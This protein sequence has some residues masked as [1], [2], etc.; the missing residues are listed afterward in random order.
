MTIST[1]AAAEIIRAGIGHRT[2]EAMAG[3]I[4]A[5]G[6]AEGDHAASKLFYDLFSDGRWIGMAEG[7]D[8]DD[9]MRM[10]ARHLPQLAGRFTLIRWYGRLHPDNCK[11]SGGK[12]PNPGTELSLPVAPLPAREVVARWMMERGY[13]TGHGDTIEDL[14]GELEAQVWRHSP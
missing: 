13:A 2:P 12:N 4:L 7:V 10:A 14:L 3:E 8:E 9:A 6:Q 5:G 1:E 11:A